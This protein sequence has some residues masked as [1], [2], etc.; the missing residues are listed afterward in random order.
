MESLPPF[1]P[2]VTLG[3]GR[4]LTSQPKGGCNPA[5]I[6]GVLSPLNSAISLRRQ[7][8]LTPSFLSQNRSEFPSLGMVQDPAAVQGSVVEQDSDPV[9]ERYLPPRRSFRE[10]S[11]DRVPS[12]QW[13]RHFPQADLD[14]LDHAHKRLPLKHLR[15]ET[16]CPFRGIASGH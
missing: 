11:D 10:I 2:P 5:S 6:R 1:H 12:H 13:Y 3:T 4:L 8:S 9:T 7:N 16:V 14:R 15:T